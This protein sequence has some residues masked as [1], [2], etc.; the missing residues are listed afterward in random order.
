MFPPQF[1]ARKGSKSF[2][3][4]SQWPNK[5]W[6]SNIYNPGHN[7]LKLYNVLVQ[8]RVATSETKLDI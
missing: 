5:L 6:S 1:G 3:Y 7:I 8:V 2:N 4:L